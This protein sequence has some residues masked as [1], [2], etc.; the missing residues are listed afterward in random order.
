VLS[1]SV[2]NLSTVHKYPLYQS[3]PA[4]MTI[5]YWLTLPLSTKQPRAFSLLQYCALF[6][7]FL[8]IVMSW[9]N[10]RWLQYF[11]FHSAVS[12]PLRSLSMCFVSDAFRAGNAESRLGWCFSVSGP[13]LP[14][15]IC[16]LDRNSPF[17]ASTK[18]GWPGAL[19]V[20]WNIRA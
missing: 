1:C 5:S 8:M 6:W 12:Q 15:F 17:V 7:V 20:C 9:Q 2:L 18:H 19:D 3:A 10:G 11:S 16:K 14:C 4:A 13:C